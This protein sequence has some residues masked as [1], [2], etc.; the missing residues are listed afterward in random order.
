MRQK[1]IIDLAVKDILDGA[2]R[3]LRRETVTAFNTRR[4]FMRNLLGDKRFYAQGME[5]PGIK[6]PERIDGKTAGNADHILLLF[7]QFLRVWCAFFE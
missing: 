2:V 5:K 4:S 1:Y 3:D 7:N 6:R